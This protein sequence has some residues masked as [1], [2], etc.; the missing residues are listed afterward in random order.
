MITEKK[1]RFYCTMKK[2]K[3]NE[4]RFE[5]VDDSILVV[6]ATNKDK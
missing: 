1:K 2:L 6:M 5:H 4:L 3:G